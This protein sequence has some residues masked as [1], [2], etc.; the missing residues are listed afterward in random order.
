M[1]SPSEAVPK[2]QELECEEGTS[3]VL[4][5]SLPGRERITSFTTSMTSTPSHIQSDSWAPCHSSHFTF[6]RACEW[7]T[8]MSFFTDFAANSSRSIFFCIL[9]LPPLFICLLQAPSYMH[10][11]G[12]E[13]AGSKYARGHQAYSSLA[14]AG[15]R[16]HQPNIEKTTPTK[17]IRQQMDLA[18]ECVESFKG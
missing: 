6:I 2:A 17:G 11:A 7:N 15:R 1:N 8:R 18:I 3:A 5:Q 13:G 14:E 12:W 10:Y 4:A 16:D 9:H